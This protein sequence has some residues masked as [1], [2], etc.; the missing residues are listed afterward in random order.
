MVRPVCQRARGGGNSI[1]GR[2]CAYVLGR[3][4]EDDDDDVEHRVVS[5]ASFGASFTGLVAPWLVALF[6]C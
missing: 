6:L 4:F 5:V 2:I 3:S 1:V